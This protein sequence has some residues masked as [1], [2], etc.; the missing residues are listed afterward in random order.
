MSVANRW[1]AQDRY[2]R[3]VR[4][5]RI[6]AAPH[7]PARRLAFTIEEALRLASLPGEN[8]GRRYYFR[9]LRVARLPVDGDRRVWLEQFQSTLTREAEQAMY[10]GDPRAASANAV[11]F[12]SEEEALE[13][14]L[15]RVL[16]RQLAQEWYWPRVMTPCGATEFEEA[17]RGNPSGAGRIVEIVERLRARPAS[18]LAVAAALF[19]ARSFD[20]PRLLSA[21]PPT[22]AERWLQELG[23]PRPDVHRGVIL[24]S[25]DAK[26]A[27]QRAARHFGLHSPRTLWLAA[28][29][30]VLH[31]PAELASGT[32]VARAR[33]ALQQLPFEVVERK[34][35]PV[36]SQSAPADVLMGDDTVLEAS[37]SV[38]EMALSEETSPP[39]VSYESKFTPPVD[40]SLDHRAGATLSADAAATPA[41]S[42]TDAERGAARVMRD[43]SLQELAEIATH[44]SIGNVTTEPRES[45]ASVGQASAGRDLHS[46]FDSRPITPWRCEGTPTGAAGLFFLLN[47]LDHLGIALAV[48]S[49]IAPDLLPTVLL[50]LATYAGIDRGDAIV[51]WLDSLHAS[52]AGA[53]ELLPHA[54]SSWPA[55]LTPRRDAAPIDFMV[56][57][58]TV[59]V[60]RWCWRTAGVTA[61]E[62]VARPGV[63][64]V[65][66]TDLDISLPLDEADVRIRRAGLDLDPGWLPWFGRVVR[67]HYLSRGEL[68]MA[69]SLHD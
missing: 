61:A 14:L 34:A 15:H 27:V 38:P 54:P 11:F 58:W 1:Q 65:N 19:A 68:A 56:R 32:L 63:F 40:R 66:R 18:W 47:V 39:L 57:A 45:A 23:G 35:V 46:T 21:I 7:V 17:A 6:C 25:S 44:P 64:S 53:D 5:A 8:E 24:L 30:I 37:S 48:D 10:G 62:I 69:E 29:A 50:R 51:I 60:R 16:A 42:L 59:A 2:D 22:V 20:V 41:S 52:E 28:M 36:A 9:H 26:A 33:R 55:N 67:F 31:A 43:A 49:G 3:H 13:I 12:R 4:R